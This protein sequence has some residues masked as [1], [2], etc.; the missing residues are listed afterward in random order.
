MTTGKLFRISECCHQHDDWLLQTGKRQPVGHGAVRIGRGM[1]NAALVDAIR[2]GA[3]TDREDFVIA[4]AR[5]A[6]EPWYD[7]LEEVR[8]I[9]LV[10]T[11]DGEQVAYR[12]YRDPAGDPRIAM[13]DD[14]AVIAADD[15][16]YRVTIGAGAG[17]G[18]ERE[19]RFATRQ[20][21]AFSSRDPSTAS[22]NVVLALAPDRYADVDQLASRATDTCYTGADP[23]SGMEDICDDGFGDEDE[24]ED[25]QDAWREECFRQQLRHRWRKAARRARKRAERRSTAGS[26]ST[27]RR[28]S[29]TR[30]DEPGR[31]PAGSGSDTLPA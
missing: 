19:A 6:G 17:G 8:D 29:P 12:L 13:P 3:R 5:H 7:R 16:E 27:G 30:R 11:A 25:L 21:F 26:G 15:L 22:A 14:S 2:D 20:H 24:D 10:A 4:E 1:L 18:G 9:H 31:C 23:D 28:R